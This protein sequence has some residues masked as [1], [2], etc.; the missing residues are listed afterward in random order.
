MCGMNTKRREYRILAKKIMTPEQWIEF[1]RMAVADARVRRAMGPSR[2][3]EL[4]GKVR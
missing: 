1:R 2:R 3:R 4:E